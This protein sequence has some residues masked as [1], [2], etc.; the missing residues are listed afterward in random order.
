[1]TRFYGNHPGTVQARPFRNCRP[2]TRQERLASMYRELARRV[3]IY[4]PDDPFVQAQ[5]ETIER[6]EA[7][8]D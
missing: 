7:R 6:E 1:M 3:E 5:R 8:G 2:A 4:G